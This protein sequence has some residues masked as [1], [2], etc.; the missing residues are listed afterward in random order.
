MLS[1]PLLTSDLHMVCPWC[2]IPGTDLQA[3]QVNN[4]Y[5]EEQFHSM[6]NSLALKNDPASAMDRYD[7]VCLTLAQCSAVITMWVNADAC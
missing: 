4:T 2:R 3:G 1:H 5:T 7:T 6:M